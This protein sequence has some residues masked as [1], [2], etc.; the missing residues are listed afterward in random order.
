MTTLTE[1]ILKYSTNPHAYLLKED[2]MAIR[3]YIDTGNIALNCQ[4]SADPFGGL[5]SGKILQLAGPPSAGKTY[6]ATKIMQNAQKAKY[7]LHFSESE[8]SETRKSLTEKGMDDEQ[9][10][11]SPI[12]RIKALQ[13]DLLNIL[14]ALTKKEKVLMVID[15]LGMLVSNKQL[16]DATSGKDKTDMTKTK[17]LKSL[18]STITPIAALKQ[19][20][21]I[22]L[23][24]VYDDIN[25]MY[26]AKIVA[27]GSGPGFSASTTITITKSQVKDEKTG[28]ITGSYATC[29]ATK[30]RWA[31]EKT[32]IKLEID[33]KKGLDR[34]SGLFDLAIDL[35]FITKGIYEE[36]NK[37]TGKKKGQEKVGWFTYEGTDKNFRKK[38]LDKNA[39][40]WEDALKGKFGDML[41][42]EFKYQSVAITLDDEPTTE[43]IK[44]V[45]DEIDLSED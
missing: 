19:V 15:S 9:F 13:T 12:N 45:E 18:F 21:F 33:F 25:S 26:G 4:I 38:E 40:F 6:I 41:R 44:E 16:D 17:E 11:H 30:S 43:E 27:G 22:I 35:G 5:P 39:K 23:N 20:P 14:N 8:G 10:I 2:K 28:K 34:Y 7:T 37:K 42:E 29:T 31:K 36:D 24:H 1:K 32:K 3:D